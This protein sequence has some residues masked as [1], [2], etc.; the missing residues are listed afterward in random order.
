MRTQKFI[1]DAEHGTQVFTD[2]FRVFAVMYNMTLWGD[3]DPQAIKLTNLSM[4]QECI[5]RD[6]RN[7][8][9]EDR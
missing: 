3:Q 1:P 6:D 7:R 4:D 2:I 9:E 8:K 5:K